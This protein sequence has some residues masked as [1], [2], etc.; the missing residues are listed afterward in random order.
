MLSR[1]TTRRPRIWLPSAAVMLAAALHDVRGA[2]WP[3]WRGPNGNGTSAETGLPER[4]AGAEGALWRLPLPGRAGSTPVVWGETIFLTSAAPPE[5]EKS[6]KDD[7]ILIAAS[8]AGKILWK[9]VLGN[10]DRAVR[11]DEGNYASPSPSTDGKRV[12]A[13]AGT[14]D[15]ACYDFDGKEVWKLNL[16]ERYGKYR[17]Q[18]GMTSTPVLHGEA[19]YIQCIHSGG[20]YLAALDKETGK[21]RWKRARKT[22][23]RDEC[24]HSYASPM[25]Y[26]GGDHELLLVHGGDYLTAHKLQDGE[27]VWRVGDLNPKAS[28]NATLRFVASP[29]FAPGLV[30]VPSAKK[31]PVHA[32]RPYRDGAMEKVERL[33]TM[34]RDTP[35]VPT[36]AVDGAL[37]YLLREDGILICV[38]AGD[39]K[40]VYRERTHVQRHRASPVVADGKV[41]CV[42]MD[43]T[44]TV[45][46]AGRK[47]EVLATNSMGEN[48]SATPVAAAGRIY[49]RTF[50]ALYAIGAPSVG[51]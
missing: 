12:W 32:L 39:G 19:L 24:E 37:V 14:G 18:F 10:G 2:D 13:L 49:L 35:D 9:R 6:G 46:R 28:Y 34:E 44:V 36:P 33:W 3:Q 23:A 38:D 42:A 16:Q 48:I 27:E 25:L 30:V 1:E 17:I 26:R 31:G 40:E 45:V 22:D 8:T 21:E 29:S 43:G 20:S 41:Y 4:W 5:A 11:V 47:F 50:K 7:L 15:F 51:G